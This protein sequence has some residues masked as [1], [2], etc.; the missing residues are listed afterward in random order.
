MSIIST[1]M[2]KRFQQR[3]DNTV[4]SVEL[5]D[6]INTFRSDEG[7]AGLLH[8]NFMAKI[9]AECETLKNIVEKYQLPFCLAQEV[10]LANNQISVS[11]GGMQY[12][13]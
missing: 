12:G 4:T 11:T 5:V 8:K 2:K 9:K 10:N 6:I 3:K 1:E 13:A 7:K